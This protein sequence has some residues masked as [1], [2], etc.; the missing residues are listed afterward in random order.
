MNKAIVFALLVGLSLTGLAR[1]EEKARAGHH[2][3]RST[4]LVGKAVRNAAGESLGNI[5][6]FVIDLKTGHIAYAVIAYGEIL[7]FGGKMFAVDAADLKMADDHSALLF[8]ASKDDFDRSTGFDANKW[9]SGPDHRF[10]KK[11]GE[12]QPAAAQANKDA[13]LRRL[14]A[15]NRLAIKNPE[16][17]TLGSV[18]GLALN[19]HNRK[20]VYVVMT[21]GGL[22]GVGA[23]YYAVGWNALECKSLDK[24]ANKVFVLNASKAELDRHAGFEWKTWPE[25][26]DATFKAAGSTGS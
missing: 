16:N 26:P 8:E 23:R 1:A 17:D 2:H 14:S 3:Y 19:L 15:I 12:A 20:V 22:A 18:A 13:E 4:D 21:R 25:A 9:P 24:T 5:E 7:G 6:D 11:T 10:G